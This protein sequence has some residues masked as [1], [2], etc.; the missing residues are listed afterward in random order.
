[1]LYFTG[2]RTTTPAIS[3][4]YSAESESCW[5]VF[6]P[7][8]LMMRKSELGFRFFESAKHTYAGS[9]SMCKKMGIFDKVRPKMNIFSKATHDAEAALTK[10]CVHL[11]F[12]MFVET[13]VLILVFIPKFC[14]FYVN[15][16][17]FPLC[18]SVIL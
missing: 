1:M 4:S 14:P 15:F 16:H 18:W 11:L 12:R 10:D 8:L 17:I 9:G 5:N 13:T 2:F 3:S 6:Q 7:P